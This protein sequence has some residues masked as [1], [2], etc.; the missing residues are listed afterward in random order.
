M[1]TKCMACLKLQNILFFPYFDN[2]LLIAHSHRKA[3][4]GTH[5]TLAL[6]FNLGLAVSEQKPNLKLTRIVHYIGALIDSTQ[7][8]AFLLQTGDKI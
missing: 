8:H 3:Q 4:Q 7:A 5:F 1:F 6:L 2:W